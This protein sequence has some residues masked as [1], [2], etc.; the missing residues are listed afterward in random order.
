M[1]LHSLRSMLGVANLA[2]Q[3]SLCCDIELFETILRQAREEVERW[4][5]QLTFVYV[6]SGARYYMTIAAL[7]HEPELRARGRILA[8]V[9]RVGL[10]VIDLHAILQ[11]TGDPRRHYYHNRSHFNPAGYAVAANAILE[12]IRRSP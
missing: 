6:P 4:G 11:E 2:N 12:H 8:A 10:P 3:R 1:T 5:G 7:T 9:R